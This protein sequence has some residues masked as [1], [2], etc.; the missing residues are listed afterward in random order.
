[1]SDPLNNPSTKGLFH[2]YSEN[3][4]KIQLC[5][6]LQKLRRSQPSA[7]EAIYIYIYFFKK[8]LY[9]NSDGSLQRE[10]NAVITT[11]VNHKSRVLSTTLGEKEIILKC[12][13]Y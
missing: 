10:H 7:S 3:S 9:S 2:A 8:T 1:L 6:W 4:I 11:T 13:R 12:C 5:S